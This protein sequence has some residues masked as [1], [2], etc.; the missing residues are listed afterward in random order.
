MNRERNNSQLRVLC[1][2]AALSAHWSR[3]ALAAKLSLLG[4][5]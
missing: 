4:E 1:V 3:S 5:L 2:T